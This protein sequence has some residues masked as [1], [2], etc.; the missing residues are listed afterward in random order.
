MGRNFYGES[1]SKT[2]AKHSANF[3]AQNYQSG[4]CYTPAKD[5]D[6]KKLENG[7]WKCKAKAHHHWG[8]C[9]RNERRTK[10]SEL[11]EPTI[12]NIQEEYTDATPEDLV[13][14]EKLTNSE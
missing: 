4:K 3:K 8:S 6:C 9:G 7:N 14:I 2:D 10:M 12:D 11:E 1:S 5:K 13:E